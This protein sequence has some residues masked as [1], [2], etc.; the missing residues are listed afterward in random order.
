MDIT[1]IKPEGTDLASRGAAALIRS[2][3]SAA[4][5]TGKQVV[6]NLSDVISLA[7]S[8]SDELFGLLLVEYGLHE[9]LSTITVKGASPAVLRQIAIG[10][11]GRF[12]E[13]C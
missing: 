10:M 2:Q 13:S 6:I 11:K 8:Y 1:V 4:V 12:E 5:D 3:V 7:A 9:F